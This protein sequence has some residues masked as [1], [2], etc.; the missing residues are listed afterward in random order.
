MEVD[1]N[2]Y[3]ELRGFSFDKVW[4]NI[5]IDVGALSIKEGNILAEWIV[6]DEQRKKI[7]K[8]I[9]KLEKQARAER[10]PKKKF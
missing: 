6:Q 10:Q 7:E 5:V 2:I 1:G 9:T 4:E 8:E 3:I